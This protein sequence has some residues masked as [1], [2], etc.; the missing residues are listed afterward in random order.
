MQFN[1]KKTKRFYCII[2]YALTQISL[3][4]SNIQSYQNKG[5]AQNLHLDSKYN[6]I[7]F[8]SLQQNETFVCKANSDC[9]DM[10][11]CDLKSEKCIHKDIFPMT[12]GE[13]CSLIIVPSIF[14]LANISGIGGSTLSTGF[15]MYLENFELTK[16]VPISVTLMFISSLITFLT[17][18]Q[19]KSNNRES[20]FVDYDIIV[21]IMPMI[22]IG[23]KIGAIGNAIMPFVI[24]SFIF[25]VLNFLSAKN[26]WKN[27][28]KQI[29]KEKEIEERLIDREMESKEVN[30]IEE[31]NENLPTISELNESEVPDDFPKQSIS[32]LKA[33]SKSLKRFNTIDPDK[34]MR[35]SNKLSGSIINEVRLANTMKQLK[36]D[37][38]NFARI[39][40]VYSDSA[41]NIPTEYD[42]PTDRTLLIERLKAEINHPLPW[43]R[44]KYLILFEIILLGD[45]ML[46]MYQPLHQIIG[47]EK[48]S[49]VF[50]F[51]FIVII[52]VFALLTK[53]MVSIIKEANRRKEDLGIYSYCSNDINSRLNTIVYFSLVTGIFAG[54]L[55]IGGGLLLTP[56]LL[57]IGLSPKRATSTVTLQIVLSSLASMTVY[58]FLGNMEIKYVILYAV[59]CAL[60]C[61][62]VCSYLNDYIKRTGKQSILVLLLFSLVVFAILFMFISTATQVYY[63]AKNGIGIMEFSKFC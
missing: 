13:I 23:A 48:C 38:E 4:R 33:S 34:A 56:L 20:D 14:A 42:Q 24:T 5:K 30:A 53:H 57:N 59:P 51:C 21:V 44:L 36:I 12:F 7:Y 11:Y 22:L 62:F 41:I 6:Q 54:F 39:K 8:R 58:T 60:A 1:I 28:R 35:L 37:Q 3:S 2:L 46:E 17:G 10:Y 18:V 43:S 45:L 15:L 52:V 16:T 47:M 19:F 29:S 61:I 55:G 32:N 63:N 50:W 9:M 40:H 26:I 49:P 25:L 31:G 27:Y